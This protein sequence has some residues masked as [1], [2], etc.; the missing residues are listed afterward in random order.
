MFF[1]KEPGRNCDKNINL[2]A[3]QRDL[4]VKYSAIYNH[5]K[6]V[7]LVEILSTQYF[8]LGKPYFIRKSCDFHIFYIH[9]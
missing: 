3:L 7:F 2:W 5:P 6:S 1:F 9:I 8:I 4:S